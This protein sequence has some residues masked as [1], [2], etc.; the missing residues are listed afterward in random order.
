[1]ARQARATAFTERSG[2]KLPETGTKLFTLPCLP[3][4]LGQICF[5]LDLWSAGEQKSDARD[6]SAMVDV[7]HSR[8]EVGFSRYSD[9]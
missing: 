8:L 5:G 2:G 1:M 3:A 9:P 7:S 4:K 6:N